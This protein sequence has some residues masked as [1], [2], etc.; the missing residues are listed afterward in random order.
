MSASAVTVSRKSQPRN[1]MYIR[2]NNYDQNQN[3]K[4]R[5]VT[6]ISSRAKITSKIWTKNSSRI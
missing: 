6:T 5:K 4:P 1:G 2:I 3:P